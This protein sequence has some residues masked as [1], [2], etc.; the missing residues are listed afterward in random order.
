MVA[1]KLLA[2][3][4]CIQLRASRRCLDSLTDHCRLGQKKEQP[5]LLTMELRFPLRASRTDGASCRSKRCSRRRP[6]RPQKNTRRATS[7]SHLEQLLRTATLNS[8]LDLEK[9]AGY[10][11][12]TLTV[13]LEKISR[14]RSSYR[15]HNMASPTSKAFRT[16]FALQTRSHVDR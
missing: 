4:V 3:T 14:G 15:Q 5:V 7:S 11:Q 13:C 1:L 12:N 8:C 16:S 2:S 10:S 6:K 9:L